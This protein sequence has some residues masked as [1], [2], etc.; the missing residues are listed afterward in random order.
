MVIEVVKPASMHLGWGMKS[1]EN[2]TAV[3]WKCC[4]GKPFLATIKFTNPPRRTSLVVVI[5]NF[6]VEPAELLIA[7]DAFFCCYN[8]ALFLLALTFA[9]NANGFSVC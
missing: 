9:W 8:F 4:D 3:A 7:G 6:N 5:S 2:F 1:T